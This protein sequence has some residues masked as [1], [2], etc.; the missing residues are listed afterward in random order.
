ML[1]SNENIA[2]ITVR[3]P[4]SNMSR[5]PLYHYIVQWLPVYLNN[6]LFT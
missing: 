6:K 4:K 3:I 1:P 5:C 2:E